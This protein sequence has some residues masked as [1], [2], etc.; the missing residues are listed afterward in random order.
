MAGRRAGG[1]AINMKTLILCNRPMMYLPRIVYRWPQQCE[2][3][4]VYEEVIDTLG[5][6]T[7]GF[8]FGLVWDGGRNERRGD[9]RT[10]PARMPPVIT[11]ATVWAVFYVITAILEMPYWY[12]KSGDVGVRDENGRCKKQQTQQVNNHNSR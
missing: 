2:N 6:G 8:W 12:S 9:D 5:T 3:A 11:P 1:E 4:P 10:P 7:V